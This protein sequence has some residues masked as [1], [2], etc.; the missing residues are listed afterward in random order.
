MYLFLLGYLVTEVVEKR[1]IS[2]I[3]NVDSIEEIHLYKD[4]A[5][6]QELLTM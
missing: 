4:I 3:K 6:N 5:R 2:A 1:I